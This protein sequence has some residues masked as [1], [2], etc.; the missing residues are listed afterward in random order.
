MLYVYE[1]V[2]LKGTVSRRTTPVSDS[3]VFY[4]V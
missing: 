1:Y 3:C 4:R 2:I